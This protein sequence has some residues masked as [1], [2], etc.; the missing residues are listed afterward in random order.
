MIVIIASLLLPQHI[1]DIGKLGNKLTSASVETEELFRWNWTATSMVK[2]LSRRFSCGSDP[3][4]RRGS[5][6]VLRRRYVVVA[7]RM[8]SV[9]R[10]RYMLTHRVQNSHVEVCSWKISAAAGPKT[11]LL[12]WR[13]WWR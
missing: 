4:R 3:R 11:S 5:G 9:V 10:S 12:F 7:L 8:R 6:M 1:M 2:L 13:V